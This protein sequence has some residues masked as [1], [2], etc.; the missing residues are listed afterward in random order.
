MWAVRVWSAGFKSQGEPPLT[1]HRPVHHVD[2]P[3]SRATSLHFSV[4]SACQSDAVGVSGR[5]RA[6]PNSPPICGD[7]L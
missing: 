5:V 1:E 3:L 2:R 4:G 6:A 7:M